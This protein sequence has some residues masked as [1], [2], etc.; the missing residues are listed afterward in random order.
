MS[1]IMLPGHQH[2]PPN[3][4][5][6]LLLVR[7]PHLRVRR[8]SR[9]KHKCGRL[10]RPASP[11]PYSP[12]R[13]SQQP[14]DTSPCSSLLS[15]LNPPQRASP[16]AN[17]TAHNGIHPFRYAPRLCR[18]RRVPRALQSRHRRGDSERRRQARTAGFG[19]ATDGEG[20]A[21]AG[22]RLRAAEDVLGG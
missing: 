13:P 22:D 15:T 21:E 9:S 17:Q 10:H 20:E 12:Q 1:K 16:T 3:R 5:P 2:R 18:R 11:T 7:K 8:V 6:T 14:L 4:L 19:A